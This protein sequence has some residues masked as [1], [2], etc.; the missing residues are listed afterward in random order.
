[1]EIIHMKELEIQSLLVSE[2]TDISLL[3]GNGNEVFFNMIFLITLL[4]CIYFY[5]KNMIQEKKLKEDV[6]DNVL[7][8][9]ELLDR[10]KEEEKEVV[11]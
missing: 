4:L 11:N 5:R 7:K 2:T 8:F 10:V 3:C 9:S 1:M 6:E